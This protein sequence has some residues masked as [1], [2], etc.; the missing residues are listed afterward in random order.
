MESSAS[1]P[2]L[3][4]TI[5]VLVASAAAAFVALLPRYFDTMSSYILPI[6]TILVIPLFAYLAS[7]SGSVLHQ[8]GFCKKVDIKTIA[9]GNLAILGLT[10]AI[11]VWLFLENLPFLKYIFGEYGPTNQTTGE[12]FPP[13]SIEYKEGMETERH[14][15][16]Q[17]LSGIVKA[18]LPVYYSEPVKNGIT[19]MYWLFWGTMLPSFFLFT[20]QGASC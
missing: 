1:V 8:Y 20:V 5:S 9:T 15:K 14:Y 4:V 10:G 11:S 16:L 2:I 3:S 19:Y 13:D 18:V 12:Q 17:P 7:I 6:L